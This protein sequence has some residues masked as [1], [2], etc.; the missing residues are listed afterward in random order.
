MAT[1]TEVVHA[2]EY[3]VSEA[4]NT[5]SRE[6]GTLVKGN[7]LGAGAVL[8]GEVTDA[9]AVVTGTGNGVPGAVTL[10][11]SAEVGEYA[12]V[13][14]DAS[15][16]GSEIFTVTTPSGVV[17]GDLTVAAAYTS[18]HFGITVADGSSDFIVTDII[19]FTVGYGEY[20]HGATLPAAGILFDA[21]D[22]TAA[23][24]GCVVTARD[25]EVNGGSLEWKTGATTATKAI[26][27]A[28]LAAV[29]IIVR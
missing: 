24:A 29:G 1:K 20:D 21:V 17:L 27:A 18:T 6:A 4:N 25:S 5:R 10:S 26:A 11:P 19:N 7:N 9:G 12:L 22:A 2:G 8:G 28:S 14:K 15:S 3:I 23:G 16:S 13:C